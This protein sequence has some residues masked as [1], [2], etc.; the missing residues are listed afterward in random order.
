MNEIISSVDD[1][2]KTETILVSC[3]CYLHPSSLLRDLSKYY[4]CECMLVNTNDG[5]K[6][7]IKIKSKLATSKPEWVNYKVVENLD[8]FTISEPMTMAVPIKMLHY[9]DNLWLKIF[10]SLINY[11][12]Q[13]LTTGTKQQ[14][15]FLPIKLRNEVLSTLTFH[16]LDDKVI[17][18]FRFTMNEEKN[19]KFQLKQLGTL[20]D[21]MLYLVTTKKREDSKKIMTECI[22]SSC[23]LK[24]LALRSS[25]N[26][27]SDILHRIYCV[28][29]NPKEPNSQ[30][31]NRISAI[32][33]NDKNETVRLLQNLLGRL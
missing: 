29:Y 3:D 18:L 2:V 11:Y 25:S 26:F 30:L 8:G 28:P 22:Y 4:D 1:F 24:N 16:Y 7:R 31:F 9:D 15:C 12:N 27:V 10:G 21:L 23:K 33:L 5:F 14:F 6:H 17:C 20:F 13:L 19:Q 32:P